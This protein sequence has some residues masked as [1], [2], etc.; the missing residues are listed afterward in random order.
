MKF[1]FPISSRHPEL[2]GCR[3]FGP[4]ADSKAAF[5]FRHPE[6]SPAGTSV[7]D[8]AISALILF[9][10]AKNFFFHSHALSPSKRYT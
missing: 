4:N 3:A 7:R 8:L 9:V 6:P 2:F 1:S 5:L 10:G